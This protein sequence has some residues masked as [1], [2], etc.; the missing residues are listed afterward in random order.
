MSNQIRTHTGKICSC[1][2]NALFVDRDCNILIL[3]DGV[4]TGCLVE[5]HFVIFFSVN[6]KVISGFGNKDCFFKIQ[7]V[8]P[9]VVDCQFC[10]STAVERIEKFRIFKEHCFFI[11]TTCNG[12]VNIR[13]LKRLRIFVLSNT[14]NAVI[15]NSGN[16]DTILYALWNYKLFFILL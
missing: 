11:F 8:K 5:K 10:S 16:R 2:L 15:I 14:E 9:S 6:I 3:N 1:V 4:C 12:I 7:T 13:E